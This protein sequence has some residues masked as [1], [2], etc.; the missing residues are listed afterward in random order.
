[1]G[2]DVEFQTQDCRRF[3]RPGPIVVAR[4]GSGQTLVL[5]RV[6]ELHAREAADAGRLVVVA[7]A[8]LVRKGVEALIANDRYES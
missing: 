8:L 7:F 3:D 4:A 1:M 2:L 6:A 5:Q